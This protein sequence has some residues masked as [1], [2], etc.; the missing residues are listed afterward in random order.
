MDA[1]HFASPEISE[2]LGA[3]GVQLETLQTQLAARKH[4]LGQCK[5]LQSFNRI[6]EQA[7]AWIATREPQLSNED[8]GA[9]L[10]AVE[11]QL[12]K[13]ADFEKSV[14]AQ[15]EK[16]A[17]VDRDAARLVASSHY[18]SDGITSRQTAVDSRS[19]FLLLYILSLVD[20]SGGMCRFI[21]LDLICRSLYSCSCQV[22]QSADALLSKERKAV[23]SVESAAVFARR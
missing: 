4:K 16:I 7:E 20:F 8:H 5:E 11:A 22:G 18:D 9:S 1:N 3:L 21:N 12:K 14:E 13:H 23:G 10:D 17:E 19:V 6:A 2:K 15:R